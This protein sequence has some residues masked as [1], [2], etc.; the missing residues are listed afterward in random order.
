MAPPSVCRINSFKC[1]RVFCCLQRATVDVCMQ[2]R[3]FLLASQL[4][5][6]CAF[7]VCPL[8][9]WAFLHLSLLLLILFFFYHL[10]F[11]YH[12]WDLLDF[13]FIFHRSLTSFL[14]PPYIP[15]L[16]CVCAC[17]CVCADVVFRRCVQLICAASL[18]PPT[19][20]LCKYL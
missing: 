3:N 15:P 12:I 11:L 2:Q 9:F 17:V 4:W 16:F 5:D 6:F 10:L 13:C 7:T 14:S 18:L 1:R 8:T 19:P 20:S